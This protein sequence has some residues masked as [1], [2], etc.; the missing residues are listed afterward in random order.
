MLP[1]LLSQMTQSFKN[2]L[3]IGGSY[4]G[5]RAAAELALALPPSHRVVLVEPHSH[6]QHL[7]VF[8]RVAVAEGFAHKAF[9][10]FDGYFAAQGAAPEKGCFVRARVCQLLA[11]SALLD[12]DVGGVREVPYEYAVLATGT[13]LSP[14]GTLAVEGECWCP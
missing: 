11:G 2:V 13:L 12:R 6:F 5:S 1:R 10:P 14:P 9:I 4:V 8:P 3:V 7:F